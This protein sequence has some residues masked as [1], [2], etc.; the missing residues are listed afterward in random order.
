M[1][2]TDYSELRSS[3]GRNLF[4][5]PLARILILVLVLIALALLLV[6]GLGLAE[7]GPAA[8]IQDTC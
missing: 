3:V 8:A 7:C 4:W 5:N 1:A 6:S 2:S